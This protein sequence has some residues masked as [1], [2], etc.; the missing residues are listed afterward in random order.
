MIEPEEFFEPEWLEWFRL[1]PSERLRATGE[2][3]ENYL[4]LGGS[5]APDVDTQSPFWSREELEQFAIEAAASR[6]RGAF[7]STEP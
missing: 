3:W 5:L 1:T 2:I 6:S 7:P 4:Q